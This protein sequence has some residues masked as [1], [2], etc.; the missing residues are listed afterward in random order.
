MTLVFLYLLHTENK[1]NMVLRLKLE[2]GLEL[3]G[4]L[5]VRGWGMN[6]VHES[7][8]KD[9]NTRMCVRFDSGLVVKLT[10]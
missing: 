8:H 5:R 2:F 1:N 4:V 6:Y 3:V 9:G 10:P 7:P